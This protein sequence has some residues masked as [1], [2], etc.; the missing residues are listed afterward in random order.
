MAGNRLLALRVLAPLGANPRHAG[1]LQGPALVARGFG[2]G[3]VGVAQVYRLGPAALPHGL[4]RDSNLSAQTGPCSSSWRIDETY[5][6]VR[7]QWAFLY[8]AVDKH[9]NTIDFYLSPTRNTAAAK[10][11]LGKALNGLKDWEK[12]RIINTDKAPTYASSELFGYVRLIDQ[13]GLRAWHRD[14][15]RNLSL[16]SPLIA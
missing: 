11:F 3:A 14:R 4:V 7:G 12:P 6:K 16:N 8:R 2:L 13:V 9:G 1:L 5:V 15:P 10:R